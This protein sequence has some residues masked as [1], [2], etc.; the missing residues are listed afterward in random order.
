M[1]TMN[2]FVKKIILPRRMDYKRRA[3]NMA[4]IDRLKDQQLKDQ[5]KKA[6]ETSNYNIGEHAISD[7]FRLQ[8]HINECLELWAHFQGMSEVTI[9]FP[10]KDQRLDKAGVH[11]Y[12]NK[13][14]IAK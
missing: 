3:E 6:Q 7:L 9:C 8:D 13:T 1:K 5:M 4:L 12:K 11:F 14:I 2:E 10:I